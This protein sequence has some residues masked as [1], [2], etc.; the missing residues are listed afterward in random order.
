MYPDRL[1]ISLDD[2]PISELKPS[3]PSTSCFVPVRF[4]L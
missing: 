2:L 4:I 3:L 1:G